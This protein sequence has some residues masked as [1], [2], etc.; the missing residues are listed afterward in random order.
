MPPKI[1]LV[2]NARMIKVDDLIEVHYRDDAV[3]DGEIMLV[4]EIWRTAVVTSI[5]DGIGRAH[6]YD[7]NDLIVFEFAALGFDHDPRVRKV[8]NERLRKTTQIIG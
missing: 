4:N 7:G 1:W 3:S 8:D 5:K 6:F 2:D